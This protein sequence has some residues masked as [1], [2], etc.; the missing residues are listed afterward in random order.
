MFAARWR[1][2]QGQRVAVRR[3]LAG[4]AASDV[5]GRLVDVTDAGIVVSGRDG[6]VFIRFDEIVAGKVVPPRPVRAAPPHRALA[7]ADLEAVAALHWRAVEQGRL[8]GWLLRASGGFTSRGNSALPL[9]DPGMPLSLALEA[10]QRWYAERGLRCLVSL[11][12]P[13]PGGPEPADPFPALRQA[14]RAGSWHVVD[15]ASALVPTGP[16]AVAARACAGIEDG[17]FAGVRVHCAPEPDPAWL[18]SYHYR[19]RDLPAQARALLLSAPQQVFVS[20]RDSTRD[21]PGGDDAAIAVARGSLGGGWAGLTAVEVDPAYR[22]RGLARLLLATVAR[23]AA[24][25]G[26]RSIYVQV[27]DTNAP[28][29]ALYLSCGFAVHHRYDYWTPSQA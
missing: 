13:A 5:V 7:V 26:V 25:S 11:P 29:Q 24:D 12:A 19:G 23:W 17:S 9:G 20:L 18:A 15:G 6:A 4:G 16:V 28:A 22:R 10:V 14:L 27:A 8:G 1:S 3:R 2:S 21:S